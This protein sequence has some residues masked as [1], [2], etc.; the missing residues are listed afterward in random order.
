MVSFANFASIASLG[1]GFHLG[2]LHSYFFNKTFGK[3]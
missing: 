1:V 2:T 3:I